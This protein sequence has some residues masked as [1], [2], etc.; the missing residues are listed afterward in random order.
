MPDVSAI[1]STFQRPQA[2][3]RALVSVLEQEA[4]PL[5]VLVCDD[6][7]MDDTPERFR[8]WAR[9]ESRVRYLRV[10][11]NRGTPGPTRNLGVREARGELVA[12]LDDDD[13]WLPAKL[14]RQLELARDTDVIG[15]N[16]LIGDGGQYFASVIERP[17]RAQVLADN[18][19]I[20]STV[21][22]S[23]QRVLD[24][25]GFITERWA[26]GVN[27]YGMWL[28]L[29]DNGA[30]LAVLAEPLALYESEGS[31]RYSAAPIGQELAVARLM[32]RHARAHSRDPL[33]LKAALNR[34]AGALLT[35][36][37]RRPPTRRSG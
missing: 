27:D 1:I 13:E 19:F 31:E 9:R 3:E 36:A 12:F 5:E 10:E 20:A 14:A 26:R 33:A 7:S 23:R 18:P 37:R 32:W 28:D 15:A 21:L 11:P 35:A 6:G 30:R 17:T 22:T 16:A 34:S 25:G 29:A 4:P 2:A 24:A 8:A